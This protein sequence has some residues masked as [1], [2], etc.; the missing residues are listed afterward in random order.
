MGYVFLYFANKLYGTSFVGDFTLIQSI[1]I[2]LSTVC[3]LGFDT[4]SVKLVASNDNDGNYLSLLY[5]KIIIHIIPITL[6]L[7]IIIYFFS[8]N[9]ALCFQNSDL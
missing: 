7:S 2:I 4:L 1:F 8:E 3:T 6:I 9:I 5:Q